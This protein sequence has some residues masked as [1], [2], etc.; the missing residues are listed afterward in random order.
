MGLG[1]KSAPIRLVKSYPRPDISGWYAPQ[2]NIGGRERTI[3]YIQTARI[4]LEVV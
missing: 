3:E 2:P 1:K 4:I